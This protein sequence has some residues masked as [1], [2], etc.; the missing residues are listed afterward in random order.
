MSFWD[1]FNDEEINDTTG[2]EGGLYLK[3]GNYLVQIQRCKMIET[4]DKNNAFIAELK[5]AWT[6]T[7]DR[8]LQKGS[9]PSVFVNMDGK[10]PDVALGNVNDIVRAGLASMAAQHG[11]EHPPLKDIPLNK[12]VMKKVTGAKNLLA[13]VYLEVYAFN[14]PTRE[15][16]DFTR[17]KW[18]V[19]TEDTI[20]K[21][22]AAAA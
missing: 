12:E 17:L 20:A 6:D 19:P 15:G 21:M 10:Y 1:K 18:K 13:G 11:Q 4:R 16:K 5:V 2:T 14:K 7:D 3:P 8:D 9:E 22:S